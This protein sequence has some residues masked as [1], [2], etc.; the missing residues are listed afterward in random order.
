[1]Y[2]LPPLSLLAAPADQPPIDERT[3]MRTVRLLEKKLCEFSVD[4]KV[5]RIHPGPVVTSYEF[6]PE[7]A[8]FMP[9]VTG[10]RAAQEIPPRVDY[11]DAGWR[12]PRRVFV[13]HQH[14]SRAGEACSSLV[15]RRD[16]ARPC[17]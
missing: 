15:Q 2:V 11:L 7:T 16:L 5:V 1:M 17:L 8:G 3:L 6:T 10:S 12:F 13:G 4:G 14:A 9:S